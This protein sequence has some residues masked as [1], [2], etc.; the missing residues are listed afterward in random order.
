MKKVKAYAKINLSLNITGIENGYHTLESVVTTIDL[1]DTITVRKRK[2]DKITLTMKG[3]GSNDL[4]DE[5]KNNAYKAGSLFKER[6]GVKGMDITVL[7]RI[8]LSG[9]LGGS[10]ADVAG[11][12]NALKDLYGVEDDVKPLADELGSDSG[13]LLTG[14]FATISGRGEKVS[15]INSDK[16]FWVVLVFAESGVNTADCFKKYD[17]KTSFTPLSNNEILERAI[18]DGDLKLISSQVANALTVPA[19][20]L[21]EEVERNLNALKDLSPLCASVSGSGS[22]VFGIFENKEFTLWA[23]DKLKKSG[24]DAIAVKT[25]SDIKKQTLFF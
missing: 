20:Q 9:G 8:P 6:F 3:V 19:T 22:T 2:D 7:K 17:E 21:N 16:D 13:Y 5:R 24:Y 11:V 15:I 10:S 12:L 18:M 23:L 1:Y 14:G 4:I 25:V